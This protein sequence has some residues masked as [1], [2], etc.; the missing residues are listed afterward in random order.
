MK[1]AAA[2][3]VANLARRLVLIERFR[4]ER[5]R[6]K[7]RFE[8]PALQGYIEELPVHPPGGSPT[9]RQIRTLHRGGDG[10]AG[11]ENL[12]RFE[13]PQSMSCIDG[14]GVFDVV[15]GVLGLRRIGR[16]ECV[17]HGRAQNDAH[18]QFVLENRSWLNK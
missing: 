18:G 3:L 11:S 15:I 12:D 5:K 1:V 8:Y 9:D 10:R 6:A 14:I 7:H 17:R 2:A 4:L 16:D 13:R